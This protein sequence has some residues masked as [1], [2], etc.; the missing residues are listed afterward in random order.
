MLSLIVPVYKNAP[1]IDALLAAVRDL[2]RQLNRDF[3]L[4]CV[5]DG[6]PDDSYLRLATALPKEPFRSQLLSLSRNFGSFSAIRAGLQAARGLR[7]AVMAADLQE[8]PEMILEFDRILREGATDVVI[9]HRVSRADPL[10]SRLSSGLFWG[11]FRRVV[12]PA[13]PAGGVDVFGCT[14]A[15]RDVI[16]RL[17]ERHSS[18][19]ALLFWVG[20]R[21]QAVPYGRRER[22]AGK[23]GWTL[24]KKLRYFSDS[25]FSFT[26]LPIKALLTLGTLGLLGSLIF[27]AVVL[28]AKLFSAI[29]VPGYAGTV[30]LITFFGGLNCFGLGI[31]GSYVW[32]TFENSKGRPNYIVRSQETFDRDS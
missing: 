5:V 24:K 13:V 32:R 27:A 16:V 17:P 4:V 25:L 2:D 6:S 14:T 30:L 29:P 10:L 26:D 31:V 20:F 18:L 28:S 11:L 12:E 9:G 15:V 3:E 21:R 22:M 8:P 7:C 23:S 1:N 19:V